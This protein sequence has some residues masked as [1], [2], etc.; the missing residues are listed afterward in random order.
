MKISILK[1][2]PSRSAFCEELECGDSGERRMASI[3]PQIR[4]PVVDNSA[5]HPTE[6]TE[7]PKD[8]QHPL[9]LKCVQN[10]CGGEQNEA[11]RVQCDQEFHNSYLLQGAV[12]GGTIPQ[13]LSVSDSDNTTNIAFNSSKVKRNKKAH[14][15]GL[16]LDFCI[17]LKNFRYVPPPGIGPGSAR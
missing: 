1:K 12:L 16:F 17:G 13:R 4:S 14:T 6:C 7:R 2:A 10:S 9:V 11:E 8:R 3:S 5:H 15:L